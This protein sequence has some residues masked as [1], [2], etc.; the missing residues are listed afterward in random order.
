[1]SN[2]DLEYQLWIYMDEFVRTQMEA[3]TKNTHTK[4]SKNVDKLI[5]F[6]SPLIM[7]LP[8]STTWPDN[9]IS[10]QL[11]TNNNQ[12]FIE[13]YPNH[14]RQRRLSYV[15]SILL[16]YAGLDNG[17]RQMLLEIPSTRER[18]M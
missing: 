9:F 13:E 16:E 11:Q 6:L 12:T 7:L 14:R 15:S 17:I 10:H 18:L 1:M 4:N 8:P 5:S 3:K 2:D